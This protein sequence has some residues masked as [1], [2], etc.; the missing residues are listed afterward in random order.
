[1]FATG[2]FPERPSPA[3]LAR[4]VQSAVRDR[5]M[6]C[7]K[8]IAY[9]GAAGFVAFTLAGCTPRATGYEV[10]AAEKAEAPAVD[11]QEPFKEDVRTALRQEQFDRLDRLGDELLKTKA[12]FPGGDWKSYRFQGALAAPAAGATDSDEIWER[13][14]AVLQRWHASHPDSMAAVVALTD[15]MVGWGWKARG[16][17]FAETVT[18]QGWRLLRERTAAVEPLLLE[19]GQRVSRT[20]DWYRDM[21]DVGRVQNWNRERV[22]A[23]FEEAIALEPRYLHVYSAMARYLMPRW[24]G[25]DGDWEDFAQRTAERL[26]GREGSVVYG[27]IA[28]QIS[29]YY[30]GA[31][32]YKRNRVSWS[33]VKQG[34]VDRET[35]Y[36][37]SLRNLNAF[38]LLAGSAA[39]RQTTRELFARIGDAWDVDVWKERRY[40]DEY[41]EW[42]SR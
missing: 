13:Q 35:L 28:W 38:C 17:G 15:A 33:R 1:M 3:R 6:W 12:R 37:F 26:G 2:I 9:H 27:H 41:R 4:S 14:I 29:K 20:P 31:D 7:V 8:Q 24:Q 5:F 42:A 23:L 39:D 22:E 21:I 18:P 30:G 16:E 25:K 11:P 34:F 19:I 32:F 40:F 36:G 10:S